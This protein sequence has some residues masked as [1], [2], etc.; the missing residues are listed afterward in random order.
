MF[1]GVMSTRVLL[2]KDEVVQGYDLWG[3]DSRTY[4]VTRFFNIIVGEIDAE[5]F[6]FPC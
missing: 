5:V 6:D 1:Q 2:D 4:V 3:P